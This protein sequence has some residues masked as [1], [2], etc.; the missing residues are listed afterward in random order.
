VGSVLSKVDP[1]LYTW[2]HP[3][4]G[5]VYIL[6]YVDDLI[7]AGKSLD[8]V[9]KVNSSVSATFD[10][11]NTGEDKDIIGMRVMRDWDANVITL[12][13]P[14]HFIALLEA[15]Q[16][17]KSAPSKTPMEAGTK[18]LKPRKNLLNEVNR[19]SELVGSL[20]YL[21]TTSRPDIAFSMGVLSRYISCPEEELSVWRQA[22]SLMLCS[23]TVSFCC[24]FCP[25]PLGIHWLW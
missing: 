5:A 11:R 13:N 21:S 8:G 25:S 1:C 22:R 24:T 16:M 23:V 9:K 18:L 4:H 10:V 7:V 19:Y 3:V 12:S 20:L 15:F 17:N 14:G 2:S 6:L